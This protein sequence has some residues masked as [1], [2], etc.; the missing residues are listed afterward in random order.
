MEKLITTVVEPNDLG[1]KKGVAL[2]KYS[3][4]CTSIDL[5]ELHHDDTGKA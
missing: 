2:R 1:E 3:D 5:L 4:G